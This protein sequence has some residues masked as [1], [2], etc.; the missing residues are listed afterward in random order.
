MRKI[1]TS[2][3]LTAVASAVL[4]VAG[5]TPA[6]AEDNQN[7][8]GFPSIPETFVCVTT[9]AP[10]NA[11]PVPGP[12]EPL[13]IPEICYLIDCREEETLQIP[14]YQPNPNP[15]VVITYNGDTYT[16]PGDVV[17]PSIVTNLLTMIVRD[18]NIKIGTTCATVG[19][20][21]RERDLGTVSCN[22]T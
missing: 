14:T 1:L 8:I 9:L 12:T 21:L 13:T 18:I 2:F 20:E 6:S 4:G 11:L 7:C 17:D 19:R 3:V 10:N 22:V 16:I 5:T 15:V